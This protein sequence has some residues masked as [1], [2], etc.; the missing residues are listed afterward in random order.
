MGSVHD[1]GD[2]AKQPRKDRHSNQLFWVIYRG[3]PKQKINAE[4]NKGQGAGFG[5][6]KHLQVA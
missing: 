5:K 6:K 3:T 1:K 4:N 2:I